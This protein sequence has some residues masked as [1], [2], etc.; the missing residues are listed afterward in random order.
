VVDEAWRAA[1]GGQRR[2]VL[3]S[4]ESGISKTRLISE[5]A[6]RAAA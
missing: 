4:G 1:V 3:V 5:F 2:G 6:Y